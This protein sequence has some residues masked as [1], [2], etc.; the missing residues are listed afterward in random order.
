MRKVG[1][2]SELTDEQMAK[3]DA[4]AN[5]VEYAPETGLIYEGDEA[6][7][8]YNITEGV[9][10]VTKLMPDGRRAITGFLYAGDFLGLS[11][12]GRFSY[13]AEAI[14]PVSVCQFSKVALER[15][16]VEVPELERRLL[17]MVTSE[18]MSAQDQMML[19][20]RKTPKEKIASFLLSVSAKLARDEDPPDTI[21]LAMSR[22]DI[23]DFLGLT[24][25]T[26]SRTLT[27]LTKDGLIALPSR[28]EVKLLDRETVEGLAEN[29]DA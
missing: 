13:T 8:V 11:Y 1:L 2:V 29:M 26:V 15:V 21:P 14:T 10:R 3:V 18:L 27:A 25:E 24:I 9:V 16:F 28:R 6:N 5:H 7:R 19:L 22:S 4:L 12:G 20:A 17:A 23:A